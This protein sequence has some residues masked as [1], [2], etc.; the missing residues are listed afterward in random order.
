MYFYT[1]LWIAA[2]SLMFAILRT[3]LSLFLNERQNTLSIVVLTS[4]TSLIILLNVSHA[5]D[6]LIL[7]A[8]FCVG[9]S[10]YFRDR[11]LPYRLFTTFSQTFWIAHSVIFEVYPMIFCCCIMLG[12]NLY[13]VMAYTDLFK[14]PFNKLMTAEAA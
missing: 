6:L 4:I 5:A 9:I 8:G 13:A 7:L 2:L 10:C 11:I 3:V 1:G 14:K 12:T